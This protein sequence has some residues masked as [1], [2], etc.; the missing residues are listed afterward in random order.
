MRLK[1]T[2]KMELL[3]RIKTAIDDFKYDRQ[4]RKDAVPDDRVNGDDI[5]VDIINRLMAIVEQAQ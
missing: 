3:D 5:Y 4:V 2:T 1:P